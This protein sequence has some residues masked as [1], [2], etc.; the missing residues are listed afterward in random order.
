MTAVIA[1]LVLDRPMCLGCIAS[2]TG[3]IAAHVDAT[4]GRIGTALKLYRDVGRCRMCGA[5]GQVT[6]LERPAEIAQRTS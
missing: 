1:A 4:L 2:K 5:I 3:L 6:S